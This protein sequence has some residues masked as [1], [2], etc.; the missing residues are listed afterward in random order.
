MLSL[1][2]VGHKTIWQ[3]EELCRDQT[4]DFKETEE[5]RLSTSVTRTDLSLQEESESRRSPA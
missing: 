4:D 1:G 3:G 5:M 2:W